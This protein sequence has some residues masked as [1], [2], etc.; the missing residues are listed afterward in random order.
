MKHT[1]EKNRREGF[2]NA[3]GI[4]MIFALA[5]IAFLAPAF[6]LFVG[7]LLCLCLPFARGTFARMGMQSDVGVQLAGTWKSVQGNL[8][9]I[10]ITEKLE[11]FWL[12][13]DLEKLAAQQDMGFDNAKI[14]T[15]NDEFN[16]SLPA[17]MT[18]GGA[19]VRED[20]K[21]V[22]VWT[23]ANEPVV[24]AI[25][26]DKENHDREAKLAERLKA[27]EEG[28]EKKHSLPSL[29]ELITGHDVWVRKS[30]VLPAE[31]TR[32]AW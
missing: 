5:V 7:L 28:A 3:G 1:V 14:E 4:L 23:D 6:S 21:A 30:L 16:V 22:L 20:R 32:S 2:I 13:E 8:T 18:G 9:E 17:V 29:D 15:G 12:N 19:K 31:A 24:C 26:W 10:M 27:I 25:R 11:V